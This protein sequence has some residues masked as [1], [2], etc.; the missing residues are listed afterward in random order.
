MVTPHCPRPR[1]AL[2]DVQASTPP[3]SSS[4]SHAHAPV[5]P[6]SDTLSTRSFAMPAAYVARVNTLGDSFRVVRM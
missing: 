5:Y 2:V 6:C 1:G 3:T 4:I